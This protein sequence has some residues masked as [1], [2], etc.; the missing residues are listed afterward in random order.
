MTSATS[1]VSCRILA[2]KVE[3]RFHIIKYLIILNNRFQH[4]MPIVMI[5]VDLDHDY[6]NN[7]VRRNVN[8]EI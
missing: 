2:M 7:F 4:C 5:R 6:L 8:N 1:A 3:L